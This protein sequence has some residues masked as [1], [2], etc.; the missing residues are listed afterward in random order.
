MVLFSLMC[1]IIFFNVIIKI[2]LIIIIVVYIC[3]SDFN[4]YKL[5]IR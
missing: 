4:L 2:N 1:D 5:E 3:N